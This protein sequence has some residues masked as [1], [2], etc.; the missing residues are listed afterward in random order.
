MHNALT[1]PGGPRQVN[2][3]NIGDPDSRNFGP[4][5]CNGEESS[6]NEGEVFQRDGLRGNVDMWCEREERRA[7][8]SRG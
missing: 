5:V 4:G 6:E 2:Y 3:W 7:V 1:G 8:E